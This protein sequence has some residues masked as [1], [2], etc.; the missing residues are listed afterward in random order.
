MKIKIIGSTLS[1]AMLVACGSSKDANNSNFEKAINAHFTKNCINI[2]PFVFGADGDSY[3]MTFVLQQ[4]NAFT[5]QAQI[6]QNNANMTRPVE[7]LSK[8]GLLSV[9][10]GTKRIKPMFSN[11]EI[12]VPT[13]VYSLTDMGKRSLVGS[14]TAMC[15][16]HYKVDEVVRF[17][18]P[19]S[20]MGQTVSQVSVTV[21]PVDVPDW[22]KSADIQQTY[23][24]DK[25]LATHSKVTR[26]VVLAS[27][28]WMD[29]NDFGR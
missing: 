12:T 17:T 9:N 29:A 10:D 18:Q 23:G 15:V 27:D 2:Q 25:K 22:T 13:K 8:A 20:A 6:D 5:N 16:G 28:G 3:P 19:N 21:S 1:A 26:T 24:L 7:I 14:G 4:K 11:G